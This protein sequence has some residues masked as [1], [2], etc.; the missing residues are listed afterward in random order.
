MY[1][2]S[3][4]ITVPEPGSQLSVWTTAV[5]G[6][7]SQPGNWTS[8]VPN[9]VGAGTTFN[10]STTAAVT[11]TLDMPVT[12][13]SLQFGNS[14]S[15]GAGYTLSGTGANTLTLNNSG[16]AAAITVTNGTH[17]INAPVILADNLTV[18]TGGTNAWTLSF[19]TA[20]SI[21]D[22]G[23]G[24]SLT[25]SGTGGTLVLSGSDNYNGG[26]FVEAGRLI[27]TNSEA[28]PERFELDRRQQ[29]LALPSLCPS[30]PRRAASPVPEPG[31]LALLAA[32]LGTVP[33][34]RRVLRS[35][36]MQR[37]VTYA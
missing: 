16:S 12:I 18:I 11:I 29:R 10:V 20:S 31:T 15:V 9:A 4:P 19:G 32:V 1:A 24:Y 27:A 26:T 14:R 3:P 36:R 33:F 25:M 28:L 37:T 5:K 13:G 17:A 30:N 2:I 7:W 35:S 22:N 23:A 8:G 6:T 21:T 34:Y